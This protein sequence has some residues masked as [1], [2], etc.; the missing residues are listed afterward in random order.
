[1]GTP[2]AFL[3]VLTLG[4]CE[5][6]Q[7]CPLGACALVPSA[8]KPRAVRLE[9]SGVAPDPEDAGDGVGEEAGEATAFTTGVGADVAAPGAAEG[10][11]VAEAEAPYSASF[12]ILREGLLVEIGRVK[13][14]I[15]RTLPSVRDTWE[16]LRR[17]I[18]GHRD[19]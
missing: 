15:G 12:S 7:H 8:L 19:P 14:S 2:A 10:E 13:G 16:E 11:L 6:S 3:T 17:E 5:P 4:P 1:M 18:H 9:R